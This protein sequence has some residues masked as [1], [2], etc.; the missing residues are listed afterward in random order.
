M[1]NMMSMEVSALKKDM[2]EKKK[3]QWLVLFWV[4]ENKVMVNE[5]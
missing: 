2:I 4:N 3:I 1:V 5:V